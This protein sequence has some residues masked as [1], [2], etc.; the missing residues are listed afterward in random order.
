[1]P[2]GDALHKAARA[3]RALVGDRV[4]VGARHP[5]ARATGVADRLDGKKLEAVEAQGKNLLFRFE[6]GHVLRSHL[7]MNGSW[8]VLPLST[9][10]PG[11]PWLVL[12]GRERQAVLRGGGVLELTDRATRRLGPDILAE[13]PDLEGMLARLRG[14][15]QRRE[16]GEALL[17]Q[18]LV[19]GIGNLWRAEALWEV[20]LSPWLR[21]AGVPDEELVAVLCAA[22]ALMQTSLAGQR[23]GRQVYRRARLPCPRCG[24]AILSRGQGDG[25]RVAYWCP[26]CQPSNTLLQ[27]PGGEGTAGQ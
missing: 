13:L 22:A 27:S 14:T 19:A 3:L 16:L 2:E 11:L 6:G 25:N 7:R 23:R 12:R 1:M 18:R 20:R 8:R 15:D 9:E 21:L 4:S 24:A 5:R 17:D 10:T 26:T